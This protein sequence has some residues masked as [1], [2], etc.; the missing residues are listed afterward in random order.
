MICVQLL[1]GCDIVLEMA[2]DGELKEVFLQHAEYYFELRAKST[3]TTKFS[4]ESVLQ[5]LAAAAPQK[6][7]SQGL[8]QRLK[9]LTTAAPVMLFIKV[10]GCSHVNLVDLLCMHD[11]QDCCEDRVNMGL[12]SPTGVSAAALLP[13]QQDRGSSSPEDRCT[14]RHVR[15]L[16]GT[17]VKLAVAAT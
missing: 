9:Q 6:D 8:Q 4:M 10:S 14:F 7:D 13:L 11:V 5:T 15:H 17:H 12:V 16:L 1:G 2:T 3:N